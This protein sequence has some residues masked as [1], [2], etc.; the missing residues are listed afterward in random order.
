MFLLSS[1][2]LSM[3]ENFPAD[4]KLEE[5]PFNTVKELAEKGEL[6]YKIGHSSYAQ[7]LSEMLGTEINAVRE[8]I[9]IKKGE[10]ALI[11]QIITDRLPEGKILTSEEIKKLKIKFIK[12]EIL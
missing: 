12:L 6:V 11:A 4:I 3:I 7:V 2:S 8:K 1:F 5:L 10:K 9:I